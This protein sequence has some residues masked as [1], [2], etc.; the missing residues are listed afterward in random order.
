MSKPTELTPDQALE[1]LNEMREFSEE[2]PEDWK[3]QLAADLNHLLGRAVWWIET[4][5]HD[6][7]ND[8]GAAVVRV[9]ERVAEFEELLTIEKKVVTKTTDETYGQGFIMKKVRKALH[10]YHHALDMRKNGDV[11]ADE[12][13]KALERALSRPWVRGAT[14]EEGKTK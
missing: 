12:C 7:D 10:Q 13:V 2:H 3:N 8:F 6:I 4:D 1:K 9:A 11:A 14:L 5:N